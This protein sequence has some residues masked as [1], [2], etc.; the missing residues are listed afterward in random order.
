MT[1]RHDGVSFHLDFELC[2]VKTQ[3]ELEVQLGMEI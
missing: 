2:F 1:D 3:T